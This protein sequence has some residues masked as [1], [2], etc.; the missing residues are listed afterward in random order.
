[1]RTDMTE[2][3]ATTI[4]DGIASLVIDFPPVNALALVVRKAIV[5]HVRVLAAREDVDAIVLR[6]A[7]RTFFAGAD[8]TEFGK[9][10]QTPDLNDVIAALEDCPKLVVAA[11]HGTVLGGG[12]EVALGAHYRIALE[13]AKAGFPEIALGLLPG[14]GGTQRGPRVMDAAAAFALITDGR[15]IS[16]TEALSHGLVDRI[17]SGDLAAEAIA[18]ARELVEGG[19]PLRRLSDE[20]PRVADPAGLEAAIAKAKASRLLATQGCAEAVQLALTLPFEDGLVA[21]RAIFDRLMG[22]AESRALRHLFFAEREAGKLV[23]I[24]KETPVGPIASAAVIGA[25]TMGGGIAMNFL[26][27]GIPVTLIEVK[28]EALDRGVATIRKNYEATAQKGRMAQAEVDQRMA[29]LSP[30]LDFAAL[31]DADLVIEAVFES[32]PVKQEIFARLDA[33]AK[34]GAVLA[35]NTSFLD[36]DM[37]ADATNRAQD[38]LGLHFFSPA[39]VMKLLEVVRGA[40]TSDATLATA[41]ALAKRLGKTAVVSRV[42][43]GFI[44]NRIMDV[45]RVAAE[46]LL[47]RGTD[48]GAIDGALRVYGFPMG[49]FQMFDLVGLDVMGRDSEARTLMGD[50]VAAGRLGQKSGGGYYDYDENRTPSAS[51][52]SAALIRAHAEHLD[53]KPAPVEGGEILA[54]LLYPVV[55]EGAKLIEEGI[56]QR[57]SDID[58]AVVAGY[59]W[60]SRTGGPMCWA[61]ETGLARI[62]AALDRFAAE[63]NQS[64]APCGLLRQ[65][66]RD[67]GRL[68]AL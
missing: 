8:I 15:P 30:T 22:G 34:P 55:N 21:E 1:M 24:A 38:V 57:A 27:A 33:I 46:Q 66:A 25:G 63:G 20:A 19:A 50:F 3:V 10:F 26:N 4:E 45:R 47:L 43:H 18:Y 54:R 56:V 41:M 29:L 52:A 35:T 5:D 9:P 16:A 64:L 65:L 58:V 49:Q 42:C 11:I 28:R 68:S 59:G 2:L 39:N 17:S 36:V 62:V 31:A 67:G 53:L 23:G 7:G 32:M 14:A 61:D 48:M 51:D 6:C 13:G 44:A 12:L 40:K 60:P 37:I